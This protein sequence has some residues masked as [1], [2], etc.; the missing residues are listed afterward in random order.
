MLLN[1]PLKKT[2]PRKF[3]NNFTGGCFFLLTLSVANF[4]F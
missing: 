2:R 1:L 4:N 3:L